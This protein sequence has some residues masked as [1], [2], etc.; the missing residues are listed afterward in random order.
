MATDKQHDV[1]VRINSRIN[2]YGPVVMVGS[3]SISGVGLFFLILWTVTH[4]LEAIMLSA[5]LIYGVVSLFGLT[6]FGLVAALW[7]KFVIR[8]GIEA[9]ALEARNKLVHYQDN[10]VV[11]INA[12]GHLQVEPLFPDAKP[13]VVESEPVSESTVLELYD[14]GLSL[15][16]IAESTG[17]TYYRIQQITSRNRD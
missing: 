2:F 3:I 5:I 9:R 13:K 7:M 1:D 14:K 12:A 16:T 15:R 8:P 6:L 17:L 11:I 4:W 10:C